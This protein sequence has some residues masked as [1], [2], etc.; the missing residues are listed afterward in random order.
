M[1]SLL[2]ILAMVSGLLVLGWLVGP[3]EEQ[4]Q[5]AQASEEL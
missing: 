2:K 5:P 4:G 3:I 1:D